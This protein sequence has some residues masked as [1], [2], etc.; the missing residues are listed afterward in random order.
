MI[1]NINEI[2]NIS[3]NGTAVEVF[4]PYS[5]GFTYTFNPSQTNITVVDTE[6][7]NN[8]NWTMTVKPAG[9]LLSSTTII[10][11]NGRSRI[12]LTVTAN[13]AGA[14]ANITANIIPNGGGEINPYNNA[15]TLVQ[16]IQKTHTKYSINFKNYMKAFFLTIFTLFMGLNVIL[17]QSADPAVTGANFV[18]NQINTGQTSLLTV[19]FANTGSTAIPVESIELTISTAYSYYTT[20]GTTAP[21]GVGAA[22]FN[23]TYLGTSGSSDVWRG[24][25][26]VAI[27][28]FDG[29]DIMLT[30][31]GNVASPGFETT[32]INVQPVDN[33]NQFND[34]QI[35][36]NLSPQLKINQGCPPAPLLSA[37]TKNNVCPTTTAD[38]T[39]LQP[40]GVS[41][42]TYEWHTVSSNPTTASFVS[43]PA[44]ATAGTYYLY[45]KSTCYSPASQPATV[46][47]TVCTS[48]DV[49]VTI[50]Q[51]LPSP[52]VAQPSFIPVTVANIGSA[53]TSGQLS[54]V[55][56]IPTG[57]LFGTFPE[58]NNG[59]SCLISNIT[60]TCT[61]SN[62]IVNGANSTFS[63]P[64]IPMANQVG[65]QLTIP[66]A[67]VSGGGEPT[68]NT[69]NNTSNIITTPN[70]AGAINLIL[71][72]SAPIS[73]TIRTNYTYT[74]TVSNVGSVASSGN[75]I[76]KDN[77]PSGI[78]FLMGTG[79]GWSCSAINQS[80]TCTGNTSI[81]AGANSIITL[82]VNP[83]T[84][85][86]FTN[87]A[88][89]IG[90]GD[91]TTTAKN[92]NT[93]VTVIG[94]AVALVSAKTF[95]Q[96][97]FNEN[98]GLMNDDLRIQSLIPL[99]QP[100]S[101]LS[102]FNYTGTE[103]VSP[104]VFNTTGKNAIV[105]WVILELHSEL[106]PSIISARRA[107]LIQRDGDIV[108][109]DGTSPVTFTNIILGN[110]YVSVRH[111]NH[112]GVMTGAPV[113]IGS[114]SVPV[115][116]TTT[117]LSNYN[118]SSPY[119][120]YTFTTGPSVGVRIMWSGNASGDSNI[121]FQGPGSDIDFIFDKIYFA[122][123]NSFGD[124]NFIRTEY[125]RT[126]FNLD[127]NTIYQGSGSDTD[128]VFFNILYFYLGNPA[129]FSNAIITQQIP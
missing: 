17:A 84:E 30:V 41:G 3:T 11:F 113:S 43:N 121:I 75:I 95:L 78:A 67:V 53:P 77:L 38:L 2:G 49:T 110:Y 8:P 36:N 34:S 15:T 54:V 104:L 109:T 87:I 21:T 111:R 118:V 42:Q 63:V 59:W 14:E 51:P 60:A 108:D 79:T 9:L 45:S 18:P 50:S 44:Q 99:V 101:L 39:T 103:S 62:S 105:D 23:W 117:T 93:V 27:Q 92:S 61:N 69:G 107:A 71:S 98:T 66:V 72:K 127:G 123:G 33:L 19:S 24:R 106:N 7:I 40:A 116:F 122:S 112:L 10:P 102:D 20:N 16:S 64:F 52:I 32:G 28:G 37:S 128:I 47:I 129:I 83:T 29:G 94:G 73:G 120:Q 6:T 12:G 22:F 26:K 97:P 56:K 81:L 65:T 1:I 58:N 85:G 5:E 25:N 55:V 35:N 74:L 80:V 126:D 96:G 89:I 114:I 31:T 82:Q 57:T 76:I 13:K 46:T 48:P 100:Y 90:G 88:N 124:A 70:V 115:N 125:A 4:I 68:A 119:A 91:P 86:I